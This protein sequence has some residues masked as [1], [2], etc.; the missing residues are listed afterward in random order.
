[1]VRAAAALAEKIAVS[2]LW[3]LFMN[4]VHPNGLAGTQ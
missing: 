4:S 3:Q 1:M 2:L